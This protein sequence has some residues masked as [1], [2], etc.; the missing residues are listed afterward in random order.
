MKGCLATVADCDTR[1]GGGNEPLWLV[2][3]GQTESTDS[4]QEKNQG[5]RHDL[6]GSA[7]VLSDPRKNHVL[8]PPG[9]IG[10]GGF[11]AQLLFH[12]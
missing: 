1:G 3:F 10:E 7:V 4:W 6:P 9:L 11:L 12:F 8:D 5:R 2:R